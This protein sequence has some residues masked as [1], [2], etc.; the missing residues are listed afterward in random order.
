MPKAPKPREGG[1]RG[2]AAARLSAAP[3]G[4]EDVV[5]D[6][7]PLQQH[8]SGTA[9][10]EGKAEPCS[11]NPTC[12]SPAAEKAVPRHFLIF[13]GPAARRTPAAQEQHCFRLQNPSQGINQAHS[14]EEQLLF[15][16]INAL[17][18]SHRSKNYLL[19]LQASAIS[20]C[21]H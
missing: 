21:R 15:R 2:A 8:E 11:S 12:P 14:E 1:R 17:Q 3:V 9:M 10:A 7:V 18:R 5:K 4:E 6:P 16:E 20:G 13:P 19:L